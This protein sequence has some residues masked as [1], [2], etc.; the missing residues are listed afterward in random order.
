MST[1][2]GS[3]FTFTEDK[4][5]FEVSDF[6]MNESLQFKGRGEMFSCLLLGAQSGVIFGTYAEQYAQ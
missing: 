2:G 4:N 1:D 3:G 5:P 6:F